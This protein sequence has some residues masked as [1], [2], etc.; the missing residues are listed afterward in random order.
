M[1]TDILTE[2]VISSRG[3]VFTPRVNIL[4]KI[5]LSLILRAYLQKLVM[6]WYFLFPNLQL[7]RRT[8]NMEDPEDRK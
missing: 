1:F 6:N 2:V 3:T 5:P 8:T 4:A 7:L